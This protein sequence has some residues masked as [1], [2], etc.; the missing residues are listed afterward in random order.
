MDK[1]LQDMLS[2]INEKKVQIQNAIE[3]DKLEEAKTMKEEL[4]IMQN[5][6]DMMEEVIDAAPVA[7]V[8]PVGTD[9][10][11]EFANA[12]RNRFRNAMNE[13]TGSAGGYTVPQDILTR[14]NKYKEAKFSMKKLVRVENVTRQE[15]LPG[16]SIP[17]RLQRRERG[18][19]D[20][21]EGYPDLQPAFLHYCEVC[22][23]FAGYRRTAR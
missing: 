7:A 5:K 21:S 20:R 8:K 16:E 1:R 13:G 17:H 23:H 15:S 4:D 11:H 2:K 12:A 22:R 18:R 19:G 6:F 10:I 9:V 3:A 14:I